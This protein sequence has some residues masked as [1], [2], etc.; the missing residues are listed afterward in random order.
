MAAMRGVLALVALLSVPAARASGQAS[1]ES[2]PAPP[3]APP[4][5]RMLEALRIAVGPTIDGRLDDS[6]WAGAEIA[7][8]FS[9]FSPNPGAPATQRTV[10]RL[11]YDDAAVYVGARLYDTAPDSIVGR[12]ARRDET[13]FSDWFQVVLDS[14]FDRRTAFAFTV[15]PR[16][17]KSDTQYSEDVRQDPGWDAVWDVA[18]AMDAEGWAAEF[19]IP[20][21]QLRFSAGA[22]G[23]RTW[24]INFRRYLARTDETS[25]WS[26]VPGG[27]GAFVSAAGDLSGL[28]GLRPARRLEIQPYLLAGLR[29]AP[30][31]AADPFYR[32]TAATSTAGADLRYGV[33]P[34][35]TL[36]LTV[37]PDFGQVEADPSVVNLSGFETFFPERRPFFVEGAE[38]FR[39]AF[40]EFPA[41]FHTRRVG[42]APQ[43][44]APGDAAFA[45]A[46]DATT[47][48]A[49]AK[50]T[51]KTSS[52]W[53][54]GL[55]DAVTG[56]EHARFADETGT[57]NAAPVEPATNYAAWRVARDFRRGASVVG[58]MGTMVHRSLP[59][60]GELD[61]LASTAYVAGADGLHRFGGGQYQISGSFFGSRVAGSAAA[62]DRVQRSPV[63]RA[64]RPDAGH[65]GYDPT[66]TVLSGYAASVLVQKRQGHWR[67]ALDARARSPGFEA[68]DL[69]FLGRA[70]QISSFGHGWYDGYRPGKLL[71][72]WRA[73]VAA[74]TNWTY[75]G[76]RLWNGAETWGE[77]QFHNR[78]TVAGGLGHDLPRWDVDAL[79]GGPAIRADARWW[80]WL[81][82]FTDENRAVS[83]SGG[84]W[85][86]SEPVTDG[87]SAQADAQISV[88]PSDRLSFSLAPS[89]TR[90]INPWQFVANRSAGP[91]S[92]YVRGRLSQSTAALTIRAGY[93][94]TPELSLQVYAQPF[95]S[96][97]DY[98]G[99]SRVADPT[100]PGYPERF[101]AYGDELTY[102]A[103]AG[104]YRVD[105]DRDGTQDFGF[106]DPDFT[107]RELRSN[108]VLRWEYRPGSTLFV[109]WSQGR[110]LQDGGG[111]L[112]LGPDLGDL[113]G[114]AGTNV[115]TVKASYWIGR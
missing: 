53:S 101:T 21:S 95:I 96:A 45:A 8:E 51:G 24:G 69:G 67:F 74:W 89:F 12:L 23:E 103:E 52:G 78:W 47:I 38:I 5:R 106:A 63:H 19:R 58:A 26:P 3:P 41:M 6:V 105:A 56:S 18:T 14:Y 98:H 57:L 27:A 93:T 86:D 20:L 37:N 80:R 15:N 68:N 43:G 7:T 35:L 17:V 60:S 104:L 25:D 66:A 83:A 48:L 100:A 55:F 115:L 1:I 94:F 114:A 65:A 70:D 36:S 9:Q 54:I 87:W 113:L 88:R 31:D 39:P 107:F 112:R 108:A 73:D 92:H 40:P 111:R 110:S 84:G 79:R 109:V 4:A 2:P 85:Y 91:E 32:S 13:A 16:G 11:L 46:P 72:R 77:A 10:V 61:F 81:R 49:A 34:D 102:D 64:N 75:G 90:A 28:R 44:S 30:G 99:F 33:T 50:L 71:R 42:R 59:A 82:V 62:L 76:E 97:G 29:R 22:G